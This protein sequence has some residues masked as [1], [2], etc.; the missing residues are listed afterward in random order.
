VG[1]DREQA[2]RGA[3]LVEFAVVVTLLF[4]LL[5]GIIDFANV[6]NNYNAIRHGVREGARNAVVGDVGSNSACDIHGN[7]GNTTTR[8]LIC[9]TK[10]RIGLP[11]S[12]LYVDVVFD[13]SYAVNQGLIVCAQHRPTSLTGAFSS[14]LDEIWLKSK[15][16]MNIEQIVTGTPPAAGAEDVPGTTS[17]SWCTAS[18]PSP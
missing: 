5:F 2:Q 18:H 14:L 17:W 12:Q 15:V 9:L 6:F 7:P 16:E 11:D 10:N 13:S 4:A 3:A 1:A 8:E